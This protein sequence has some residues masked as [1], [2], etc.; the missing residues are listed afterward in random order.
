MFVWIKSSLKRSSVLY[1]HVKQMH[2]ED[3]FALKLLRYVQMFL[4][5]MAD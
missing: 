3:E 1:V 2:H 5:I 4:A